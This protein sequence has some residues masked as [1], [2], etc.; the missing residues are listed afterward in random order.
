[1]LAS[2]WAQTRTT[3][4]RY[5]FGLAAAA[6]STLVIGA[7]LAFAAWYMGRDERLGVL[8]FPISCGWQSQREF[9][10]ATSLL[11]LFEFAEAEAAY[12]AIAKRDPGCAIAYWASP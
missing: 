1:M 8:D 6:L 7:T 5:R 11:H 12:D 4:A 2:A 10:R 3:L 9:T